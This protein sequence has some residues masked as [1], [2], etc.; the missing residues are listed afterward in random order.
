MFLSRSTH[1]AGCFCE[2]VANIFFAADKILN[3][4]LYAH[5]WFW[6]HS[7][8]IKK[9]TIDDIAWKAIKEK[10]G[11]DFARNRQQEHYTV[12]SAV[13]FCL[14]LFQMVRMMTIWHPHI[15]LV[16]L[17]GERNH[18][19]VHMSPGYHQAREHKWSLRS[20][21]KLLRWAY[22]CQCTV[23]TFITSFT[24]FDYVLRRSWK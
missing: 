19:K 4:T 21:Y 9:N 22:V 23:T 5:H 2:H 14:F 24:A 17:Y 20:F 12:V 18:Q 6:S 3:N 15:F 7:V 11:Q 8:C 16:C 10:S 13:W 1:S